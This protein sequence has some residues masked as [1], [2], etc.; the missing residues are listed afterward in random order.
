M[1]LKSNFLGKY[2]FL[3][4]VNFS[5]DVDDHTYANGEREDVIA[6]KRFDSQEEGV[7]GSGIYAN[8]KMR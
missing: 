2:F 1:K 3:L 5:L 7:Y 6:K 4:F 8:A